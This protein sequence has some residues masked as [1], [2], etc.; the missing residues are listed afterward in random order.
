MLRGAAFAAAF[1]VV[2]APSP[3]QEIA[4]APE[5]AVILRLEG[6]AA[7][8]ERGRAEWT[9][10]DIAVARHLAGLTP[11]EAPAAS[12]SPVPGGLSPS[13]PAPIRPGAVRLRFMSIAGRHSMLIVENGYDR[14]LVYR[15]RMTRGGETLP[16]DVCLVTPRQ[17][18]FE[19]WP[20]PIERIQLSDLRLVAWR[21][22]DPQPCR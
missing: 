5:E 7:P 1:A 18:G 13:A 20:H 22:G 8:A 4:L 11:P 21:Q 19:H 6:D 15:A 17:R 2:A 14:A 16:T 9:P 10:H 12:A 3:A